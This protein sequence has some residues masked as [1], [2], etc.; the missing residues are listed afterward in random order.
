MVYLLFIVGFVILIKGADLLVDG[1]TI[2]AK[3]YH[4]SNLVIGLT[5]VSMGTSLPE[6]FVNIMAS[7]DGS[8]GIAIG[9]ILGSNI[10]NVLLILGLTAT[11][12]PL[13]IQKSLYLSEIPMMLAATFMVG[14]LANAN[15][16]SNSPGLELSRLD[17]FFLL[18]FFLLFMGYIFSIAN[19]TNG[20]DTNDN[21]TSLSQKTSKPILYIGIGILG[22]YFGGNW[23]V[24]GAVA[25]AETFNLSKSFVGLSIVAIGTSLP[26]L[27]T[28]VIAA[29]KGETDIAMG[30]IIGSNI[31]NVLW[32]LGLSALIRPLAFD[33]A[34]NIDL[35][36]VIFSSTLLIFAIIAGKKVKIGRL[37]GLIFI[38]IYI[39][40]MC[41]VAFR[42]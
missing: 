4:I 14:F 27:V 30:N 34:S 18:I 2:L 36:M 16:L 7:I 21:T 20:H 13:P 15:F 10:S 40:Y 22:L 24:G 3:K 37:S 32:V 25:L 12:N 35:G 19:Y 6:L 11:I 33:T 39:A 42:G 8:P 26:E 1:S 41:F 29:K 9:N 38:I 23:V 31:F 17:G 28:S 5:I